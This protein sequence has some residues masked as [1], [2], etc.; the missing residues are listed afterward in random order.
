MGQVRSNKSQQDGSDTGAKC[1]RLRMASKKHAWR[2]EK[3][4][5]S[6][7]S[8]GEHNPNVDGSFKAVSRKKH[9]RK[10]VFRPVEQ[11]KVQPGH[12]KYDHPIFKEISKA[13]K[14]V[15]D[16][17]VNDITR[18]LAACGLESRYEMRQ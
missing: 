16:M 8:E 4:A 13:N 7:E 9:Q 3:K 15:N 11:P 10:H 2:E 12:G 1:K 14:A 17:S 6:S 5:E 18:R